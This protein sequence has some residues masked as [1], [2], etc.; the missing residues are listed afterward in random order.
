MVATGSEMSDSYCSELAK[1]APR[2][3]ECSANCGWVGNSDGPCLVKCG[4]GIL[5]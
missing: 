4:S 3:M 1:P 2:T 5:L